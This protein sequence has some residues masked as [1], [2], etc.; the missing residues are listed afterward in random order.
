MHIPV[1]GA[2]VPNLTVLINKLLLF[3]IIRCTNKCLKYILPN[4]INDTTAILSGRND[5][6]TQPA[7]VCPICKTFLYTKIY[8]YMCNTTFVCEGTKGISCILLSMVGERMT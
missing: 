2:D 4:I 8:R 5:M 1:N 6:Y 3:I 7:R